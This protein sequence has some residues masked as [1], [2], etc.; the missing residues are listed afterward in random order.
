MTRENTEHISMTDTL[1]AAV[2]RLTIDCDECND[3]PS[4]PRFAMSRDVRTVLSA[5]SSAQAEIER[6]KSEVEGERRLVESYKV[7]RQDLR[8]LKSD[9]L[10]RA[11]RAE[12]DAA[13]MRESYELKVLDFANET[14]RS[15]DLHTVLAA[16]V[17]LICDTHEPGAW[18]RDCQRC[19]WV[20]RA[21]EVLS[22]VYVSSTRQSLEPTHD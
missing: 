13:R 22:A 11:A 7:E 18:S 14:K 2:K 16:G 12:A 8:D 5:L 6:L 10:V 20:L 15:N 19:A 4:D 1:E 21:R 17:P 3:S 9:A